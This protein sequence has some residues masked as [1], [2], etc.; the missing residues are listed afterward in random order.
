MNALSVINLMPSGK[1]Q[2]KEFANQAIGIIEA[3]DINPLNAYSQIIL[4]EKAFDVLTSAACTSFV[5][6]LCGTGLTV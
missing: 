1:D 3:G 5:T 2:I 4:A 6:G